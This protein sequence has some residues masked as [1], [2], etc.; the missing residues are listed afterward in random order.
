MSKQGRPERQS[1]P[2]P[3]RGPVKRLDAGAQTVDAKLGIIPRRVTAVTLRKALLVIAFA[4][5]L[6]PVTG[7]E[8]SL[9]YS[10]ALFPVIILILN[11][12]LRQPPAIILF[13]IAIFVLICL[14]AMV[15]Q[16]SFV[17]LGLRRFVSFAVFMTT[18]TFVVVAI[19]AEMIAA[20]KIAVVLMAMC[21]SLVSII[22]LLRVD[23]AGPVAFEAKNIVGSQRYGFVYL[24]ALWITYFRRPA[25]RISAVGKYALMGTL[26]AGLFLT[27]SR[28][29]LVALIGSFTVFALVSLWRWLRRPT[30]RGIRRA[31]VVITGVCML[32]LLVYHSFP[33]TFAFYGDRLFG[34]LASG[35]VTQHLQD[36]ETS[37]G[38][39]LH[40]ISTSLKYVLDNPLTGSGYL[41]VWIL[42]EALSGSAHNQYL[43]VLFRTGAPGFC[44]FMYLLFSVLKYLYEDEKALFWGF[45]AFLVYGLFHETSKESQGGFILAFLLGI[46]AQGMRSRMLKSTRSRRRLTLRDDPD[47]TRIPDPSPFIA[48]VVTE[49]VTF[50][51]RKRAGHM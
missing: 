19:D 22:V 1:V 20:F 9:N 43:D 31:G 3:Q 24:L 15:Y 25:R 4:V 27:F 23:A 36:P 17:D 10:F 41:G 48:P 29:S 26:L 11:G 51:L 42:P 49:V 40:I 38:T 28:G 12:Q 33:V 35:T 5:F 7:W 37:E 8:L 46:S 14:I 18:F 21:F 2:R 6:Y 34:F 47:V 39:R 44:A 16:L 45:V 50:Q 32:V 30:S 13:I